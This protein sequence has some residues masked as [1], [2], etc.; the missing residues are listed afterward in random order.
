MPRLLVLLLLAGCA[1]LKPGEAPIGTV[2]DDVNAFI[3]V[4]AGEGIQARDTG[5]A[6]GGL[7]AADNSARL[8]LNARDQADVYFF[9]READARTQASLVDYRAYDVYQ[10][11]N[12]VLIHYIKRDPTLAISLQNLFGIPR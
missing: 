7:L 6:G 8:T 2:Y 9:T 5:R 3:R 4:L 11:G 10:E 12:I 1:G